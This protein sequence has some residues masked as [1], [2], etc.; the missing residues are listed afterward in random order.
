M[1]LG[2]AFGKGPISE[3]QSFKFFYITGDSVRKKPGFF[4]PRNTLYK[5]NPFYSHGQGFFSKSHGSRQTETRQNR[6][7]KIF[8]NVS[9][10]GLQD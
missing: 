8:L 1:L 9:S 7:F 6:M 10:E 2:G 5:K 3:Y 4:F